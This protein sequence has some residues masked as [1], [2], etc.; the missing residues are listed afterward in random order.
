MSSDSVLRRV[1]ETRF[2]QGVA[3]DW[4]DLLS[5]LNHPGFPGRA[6]EFKK[7]LADA[8]LHHRITPL[9]FEDLTAI[10]RDSQEDVDQFLIEEIWNQLYPNEPVKIPS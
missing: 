5:F 9:E 7:E 2:T 1:L 6:R 4:D 10:D 3:T 8:I